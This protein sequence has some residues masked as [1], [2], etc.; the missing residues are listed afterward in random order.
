MKIIVGTAIKKNEELLMVQEAQKKCYGQWNFPA[1]HLDENE[2]IFEGAIRETK[3]E[4]GYDVKLTGILSIQNYI[5]KESIQVIRITFNAEIISGEV[6]F[7][8]SEILDVKWIP[9][10]ELKQMKD[11]EIRSAEIIRDIVEDLESGKNYSLDMIK[12][13]I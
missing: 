6:S 5:N 9:V 8:K 2:S 12:N 13:M 10:K 3:E 7:D 1:G 4:T 11:I